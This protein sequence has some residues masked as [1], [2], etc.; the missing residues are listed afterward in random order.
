MSVALSSITVV[1]YGMPLISVTYLTAG[2]ISENYE[3]R[4]MNARAVIFELRGSRLL[5]MQPKG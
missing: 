5:I 3:R 1:N 4:Q 2:K